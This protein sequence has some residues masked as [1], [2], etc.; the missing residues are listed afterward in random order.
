M[1]AA[2]YIFAVILVLAVAVGREL[3]IIRSRKQVPMEMD[4]IMKRL[5][6]EIKRAERFQYKVGLIILEFTQQSPRKIQTSLQSVLPEESIK[7][8]TREYDL[9]YKLDRNKFFLALPFQTDKDIVPV[10]GSRLKDISI[11]RKWG[12]FKIGIS[13]YPDDGSIMEEL[14]EASMKKLDQAGFQ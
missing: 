14:L 5:K 1:S 13:L 12:Q 2:P 11:A 8:E 4:E 10:I 6:T 3:M 7:K 9:I